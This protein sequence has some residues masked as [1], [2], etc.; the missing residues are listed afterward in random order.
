MK[1]NLIK[2]QEYF[3][4]NSTIEQRIDVAVAKENVHKAQGALHSLGILKEYFETMIADKDSVAFTILK[5]RTNIEESK[6]R[7]ADT[8]YRELIDLIFKR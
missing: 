1:V 2:T 8:I 5:G 3:E 7:E 4:N 6:L